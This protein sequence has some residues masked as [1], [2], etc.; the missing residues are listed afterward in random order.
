[1]KC[2]FIL[3]I[4]SVNRLW[5]SKHLQHSLND[6]ENKYQTA[7]QDAGQY[8]NL[9]NPADNDVFLFLKEQETYLNTRR[10]RIKDIGYAFASD[11]TFISTKVNA[12]IK[13]LRNIVE[14]IENFIRSVK[15]MNN[16]L[17]FLDD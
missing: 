9:N 2:N 14:S 12:A 13:E 4:G 8:L 16:L 15:S 11:A 17:D 10:Q 6:I 7:I 3:R 5:L 1:M